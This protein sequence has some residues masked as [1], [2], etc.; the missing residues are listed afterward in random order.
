[1]TRKITCRAP[2]LAAVPTAGRILHFYAPRARSSTGPYRIGATN[3][4]L[5]VGWG[6]GYR[7]KTFGF[8]A[9]ANAVARLKRVIRLRP[10][11]FR[12]SGAFAES[13]KQAF[14]GL[15]YRWPTRIYAWVG[16]NRP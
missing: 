1:M 4:G 16:P 14:L 7:A 2:D 12:E 6:S 13:I 11:V 15:F 3:F 10:A 5:K 8:G 9:P